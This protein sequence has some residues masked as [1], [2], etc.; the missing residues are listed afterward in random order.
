MLE[1]GELDDYVFELFSVHLSYCYLHT[2]DSVCRILDC[3]ASPPSTGP[4]SY[5]VGGFVTHSHDSGLLK[6]SE[7]GSAAAERQH[8]SGAKG[9]LLLQTVKRKCAM[10]V[11]YDT[12]AN[13]RDY[14]LYRTRTVQYSAELYD[15]LRK[16]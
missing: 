10:S 3:V 2:V 12:V 13:S 14:V 8:E 6:V 16:K 9:C 11:F 1:N 15:W 5:G 4:A 7:K